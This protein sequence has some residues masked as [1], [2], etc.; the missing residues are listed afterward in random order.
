M[1]LSKYFANTENNYVLH[2]SVTGQTYAEMKNSLN[3]NFVTVKRYI[4]G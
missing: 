4:Y 3:F 2:L 1:C